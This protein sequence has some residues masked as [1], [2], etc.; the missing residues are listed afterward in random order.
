MRH[1]TMR[2]TPQQNGLVERMNRTLLDKVRR[3]FPT[4]LEIEF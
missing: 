2:M 4:H 3:L 1:R